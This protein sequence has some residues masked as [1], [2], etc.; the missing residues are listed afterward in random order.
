MPKLELIPAGTNCSGTVSETGLFNGL[1]DAEMLHFTYRLDKRGK[2]FI[3]LCTKLMNFRI[4]I[5][6]S[7]Q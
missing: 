3:N 5:T 7:S 4:V 1:P 2:G 6:I